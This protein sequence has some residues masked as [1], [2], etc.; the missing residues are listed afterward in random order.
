MSDVTVNLGVPILSVKKY[1]ELIGVSSQGVAAR[2]KRGQLPVVY[3]GKTPFVNVAL[4]T[5]QALEAE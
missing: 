2:I 3:H 1:A 5:K 4:I